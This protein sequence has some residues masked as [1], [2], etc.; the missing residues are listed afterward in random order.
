MSSVRAIASQRRGYP[1][2]APWLG[3]W[4]VGACGAGA[5][6]P[7]STAPAPT[8]SEGRPGGAP[9]VQAPGTPRQDP[10][11]NLPPQP[12]PPAQG[13]G[14]PRDG[15]ANVMDAA[16]PTSTDAAA[17]DSVAAGPAADGGSW[18]A[19]GCRRG[20]AYGRHGATDMEVLS[21]GVAWWYNWSS[22]P[23]AE[24]EP[25]A[26]RLGVEFVPMVW[27]GRFD[28]EQ[29]VAGIPEGAK[30]LLGFN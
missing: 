26:R 27:G 14:A 30:F 10:A 12:E 21:K 23:E 18:V 6:D 5:S 15:S 20:L 13:P 22:R 19:T 1:S 7:A 25:V 24:A 29:L 9:T 17:G 28:V 11:P 2:S 8:S 3:L 16:R 4:L